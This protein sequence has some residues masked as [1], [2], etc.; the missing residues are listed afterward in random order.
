MTHTSQPLLDI[1]KTAE[2]MTVAT[3]FEHPAR[4]RRSNACPFYAWEIGDTW[5]GESQ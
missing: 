1:A 2:R 5:S 3:G 4:Q